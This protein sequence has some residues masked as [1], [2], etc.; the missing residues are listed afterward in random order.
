MAVPPTDDDDEKTAVGSPAP[1]MT[2]DTTVYPS[3]LGVLTI[4]VGLCF[5]VLCITLV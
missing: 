4:F 1:E 5:T 2:E 3:T